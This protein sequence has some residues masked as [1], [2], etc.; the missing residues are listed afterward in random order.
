[1][2]CSENREE[3]VART[4]I[5]GGRYID[6]IPELAGQE[7]DTIRRSS[8]LRFQGLPCPVFSVPWGLHGIFLAIIRS[9]CLDPLFWGMCSVRTT[10]VE[11]LGR[12]CMNSPEP[13]A[14]FDCSLLRC[15]TGRSCSNLRELR[16][17]IQT[18]P[19]VVL[20]HHM[21][22]C[23]L[24]DHFSLYEFPNDLAR[25]CWSALGDQIL[26]EH[27]GVVDPY[28]HATTDVLRVAL[29]DAIEDRL[30]EL[31]RVPWCHPGLELHLVQSRLV[32]YD[33]GE[34]VT[35]PA[36]LFE[37]IER[38]SSRSLFYHVHEGRRRSGG[39]ADDFSQWLADLGVD[40]DALRKLREI[41]FYFLNLNQLRDELLAIFQ[42]H[43]MDPMAV[44]GPSR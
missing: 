31:D 11:S 30:W 14:I 18:V 25:W 28:R 16:D 32:I 26:A 33:T 22:R 12:D 19:D 36:A 4:G 40:A 1:M 2:H 10:A 7:K 6:S 23:A 43:L 8:E 21:M 24:E 39:K 35:T 17:A 29:L 13:F 34:R 44:K 38:M 15:P 5:L 9:C 3:A 41:D 20:E 42:H 27:L 37:A